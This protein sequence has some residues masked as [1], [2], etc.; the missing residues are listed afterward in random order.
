[1]GLY[2]EGS[3]VDTRWST[4]WSTARAAAPHAHLI[5]DTHWVELFELVDN[6]GE[7]QLTKLD[8]FATMLTK[9]LPAARKRRSA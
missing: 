3:M 7:D 2:E 1:M 5:P 9:T 4:A 6:M 8:I